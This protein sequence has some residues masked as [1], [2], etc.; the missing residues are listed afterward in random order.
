MVGTLA[1]ALHSPSARAMGGGGSPEGVVLP[2]ENEA[3]HLAN[4]VWR[5]KSNEE[6]KAE[7]QWLGQGFLA[8]PSGRV[9]TP[10]GALSQSFRVKVHYHEKLLQ[11]K[12]DSKGWR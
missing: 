7:K 11:G 6:E 4:P 2:Q 5:N 3:R 1:E 12:R 8:M 10:I 9:T